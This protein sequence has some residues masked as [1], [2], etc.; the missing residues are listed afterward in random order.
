MP[1][2]FAKNVHKK[3]DKNIRAKNS[4]SSGLINQMMD[5]VEKNANEIITQSQKFLTNRS[6]LVSESSNCTD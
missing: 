1:K 2:F 6:R 5:S 4:F 3:V